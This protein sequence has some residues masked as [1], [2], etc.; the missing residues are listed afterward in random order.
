MSV[1]GTKGPANVMFAESKTT[2]AVS[3]AAISAAN[4][5]QKLPGAIR[6][7]AAGAA[8]SVTGEIFSATS[9]RGPLHPTV[10]GILNKIPQGA[11]SNTHGAC[12]E[13]KLVSQMLDAGVSP[14]GATFSV[15]RVR[16]AGNPNHG[17]QLQ[18]CSTCKLLLDAINKR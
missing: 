16:G 3:E 10:Q 17:T 4:Q 6:P 12:C 15:V 5:A 7:G 2:V 18:P 8:R 9:R 1:A 14:K 13:P 11:I